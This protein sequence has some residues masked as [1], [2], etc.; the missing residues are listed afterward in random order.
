MEGSK[1]NN[2]C[3]I[4]LTRHGETDWNVKKIVQGHT[5]N[6]LNKTGIK[7]AKQLRE[8]L[9]HV[10][11]DAFYSSDLLRAKQT[12]EIVA[13]NRKLAV[14]TTKALRE[15][16]YGSL[17][18]K[19][20]LHLNKFRDLMDKL[21]KKDKEKHDQIYKQEGLETDEQ[22]AKR[23]L[24]FLREIAVGNP[25]KTIFM[26]GHGGVMRIILT[27]LTGKRYHSGD[28]L[29]TAYL[30]IKCD[31]VDFFIEEIFGVKER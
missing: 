6:P 14:Q 29:N 3:T 9:A 1:S 31:G 23:L 5:N 28:I 10:K 7:Q 22:V 25:E 2:Y 24:T 12:A 4:Y 26:G 8:K 30:V 13:L 27:N 20:S 16:R 15:R 21:I 19:E 18:G 17:E 11:F